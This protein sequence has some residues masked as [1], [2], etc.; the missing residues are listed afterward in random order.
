MKRKILLGLLA[1]SVLSLGAAQSSGGSDP[2]ESEPG[3]AAQS[4]TDGMLMY[5]NGRNPGGYVADPKG[6]TL[7][8]LVDS[9]RKIL[10]CEAECLAAC[11]PYTG[12]AAA[13]EDTGLDASLVATTE[14]AD[15]SE[16]VTYNGYPLYLFSQDAQP[17]ALSGQ[18][19]EGFGGVWYIVTDKGEPLESDPPTGE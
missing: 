6:N 2:A 10:P 14:A 18:G 7:Y 16:Q 13:D 19:V 3:V 5:I 9:D 15:G 1:A 8:T 17:G 11:P 4:Q 12:E